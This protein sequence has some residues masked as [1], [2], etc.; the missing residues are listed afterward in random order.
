MK[1]IKQQSL[2]FCN[3]FIQFCHT[4]VYNQIYKSSQRRC[5]LKNGALKNSCVRV[6]FLAQVFSVN[7][8][9]FLRT[10]F[11]TERI[12][13]AASEFNLHGT[14]YN[15]LLATMRL[16]LLSRLITAQIESNEIKMRVTSLCEKC[17]NAEFSVSHFP[18]F[19]L[20]TEIYAVLIRENTDKKKTP[21][22]DTFHAVN[23]IRYIK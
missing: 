1:I 17:L 23:V 3:F 4:Q 22:L 8:A 5:S 13:T 14:C 15:H 21:Y 2:R 18:V 10:L 19:K 9:K 16:K 11:L 6:S 12:Q 20:N 7:S